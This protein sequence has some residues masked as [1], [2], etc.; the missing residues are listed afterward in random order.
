MTPEPYPRWSVFFSWVFFGVL[1]FGVA[2][3]GAEESV[4]FNRAIYAQTVAGAGG[5][6]HRGYD[7]ASGTWRLRF[8]NNRTLRTLPA[9]V[10]Q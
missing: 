7:T 6:F 3:R 4:A 5:V 8:V 1:L 2:A 10:W 9:E